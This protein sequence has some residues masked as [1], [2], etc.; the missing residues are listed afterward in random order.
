MFLDMNALWCGFNESKSTLGCFQR[1]AGKQEKQLNSKGKGSHLENIW[2]YEIEIVQIIK[3]T[4]VHPIHI[5]IL[6][7]FNTF[8]VP[9]RE[10]ESKDE[11]GNKWLLHIGA[12]VDADKS[13]KWSLNYCHIFFW[14]G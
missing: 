9:L 11:S 2:K 7:V 8:S 10:T 14:K 12:E 6:G 13:L 4:T 5:H 1:S 3:K